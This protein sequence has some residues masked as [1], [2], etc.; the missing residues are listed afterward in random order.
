MRQVPLVRSVGLCTIALVLGCGDAA[1][2][3]PASSSAMA[4]GTQKA[5]MNPAGSS[6]PGGSTS[7]MA[8]AM[9]PS[10]T[11]TPADK[12]GTAPAD[13]GLKVGDKAPDLTLL[14]ATGSKVKLGDIY[15]KGPTYVV[16][17]RGGWCPFC[18]L[19]IHAL[20]AAKKDF[21]AKGVQLVAISVDQPTEEAKTQAKHEAPFPFLS[22]SDLAAHEAFKVVHVPDADEKAKLAA[23]GLDLE[24]Y[25]GKKH[26]EF[27]VPSIF[28]VDKKGII[29]LA[30]VDPDFKTRP[31]PEEMLAGLSKLP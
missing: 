7:A 23:H 20:S 19:Q 21:D 9:A 14:D 3:T 1:Q 16:F 2:G 11:A 27:A 15:A 10:L 26:G 13:L 29:R 6:A 12:F 24:A 18:N 30:H 5:P 28:L 8:S 17:Y 25:S 22:D 31:T 4:V